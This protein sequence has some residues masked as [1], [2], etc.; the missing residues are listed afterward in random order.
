MFNTVKKFIMAG[1]SWAD[2]AYTEQNFDKNTPQPED[3]GLANCWTWAH[4]RCIT[5]GLGNLDL[6]DQLVA[7][8]LDPAVPIVWVWTEPGRDYARI[9]GD[10]DP[11]GWM[12]RNDYF[13]SLRRDL[14]FETIDRIVQQL[15][16]NPIGFIGGLS[17]FP[18]GEFDGDNLIVL[19]P[20]WQ[21]WI[22]EQNNS[23][24]FSIGWGASDVGWRHHEQGVKPAPAVLFA[25]D[26]QI[27]EWCWWQDQGWFCHEHPTPTAVTQF[28]QHLEPQMTQ[29]L[30]R[31]ERSNKQ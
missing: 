14:E 29:W 9:T 30:D 15:P 7:L 22:A 11:H 17:D 16:N 8:N 31:L 6:L 25:W 23:K 28:A 24:W 21:Q 3:F 26:E 27:K 2:K 5:P 10:T 4:D 13:A 12:R 20:S 19:H 1:D 18:Q